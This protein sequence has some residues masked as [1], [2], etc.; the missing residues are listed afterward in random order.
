MPGDR[1]R[2]SAFV[3]NI[4]D[5]AEEQGG[6]QFAVLSAQQREGEPSPV[7]RRI[8]AAA[9]APGRYPA[10]DREVAIGTALA[11]QRRAIQR[12]DAGR[13]RVMSQKAK[14]AIRPARQRYGKA[15][16]RQGCL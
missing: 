13:S 8:E 3:A 5:L 10:V 2:N 1:R 7:A 11:N 6:E 9:A 4:A 14:L 12:G 16:S 15:I